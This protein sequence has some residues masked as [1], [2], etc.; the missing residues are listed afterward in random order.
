MKN[1]LWVF[2]CHFVHES[3]LPSPKTMENFSWTLDKSKYDGRNFPTRFDASLLF[4][5]NSPEIFP[6]P[7][8]STHLLPTCVSMLADVINQ[9]Y[10]SAMFHVGSASETRQLAEVSNLSLPLSEKIYICHKPLC[11]DVCVIVI[12]VDRPS[13][14]F[15]GIF[16]LNDPKTAWTSLWITLNQPDFI[17]VAVLLPATSFTLRVK[18]YKQELLLFFIIIT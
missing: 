2:F 16:S 6:V 4:T 11:A 12:V 5:Q 14:R 9:R 10:S 17:T 18:I 8:V 1:T 3:W 7:C 15:E 13:V